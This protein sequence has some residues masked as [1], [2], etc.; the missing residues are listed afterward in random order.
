MGFVT[1][2]QLLLFYKAEHHNAFSLIYSTWTDSHIVPLSLLQIRHKPI[3]D[4]F[5][6]LIVTAITTQIFSQSFEYNAYRVSGKLLRRSASLHSSI[7]GLWRAI[8]Y[9]YL[10]VWTEI[11]RGEFWG[12][13]SWKLS[14]GERSFIIRSLWF[15]LNYR[16]TTFDVQKNRDEGELLSSKTQTVM[17]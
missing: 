10:Y 7:L 9:F 3:N 6:L 17:C 2:R 12:L 1:W 13:W 11:I 15:P 16:I 8:L 14:M 5:Y 4:S